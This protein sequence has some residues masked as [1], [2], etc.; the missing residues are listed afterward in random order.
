MYLEPILEQIPVLLYEGNYDT[1]DGAYGTYYWFPLLKDPYNQI[2]DV[3]RNLW[4]KDGEAV[5]SYA[6]FENLT[7]IVVND[8]GHYAP[9]FQLENTVKMVKIFT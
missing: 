3:P 2:L 8:A 6:I 1:R 4:Y 5:G 7:Y 9:Y